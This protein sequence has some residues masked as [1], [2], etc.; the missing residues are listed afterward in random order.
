LYFIR[1]E[2]FVVYKII[3]SAVDE[4]NTNCRQVI[5]RIGGRDRDRT[6]DLMLAKQIPHLVE[7]YEILLSTTD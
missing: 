5:E 6:C 3:Y 2:D 1:D 4:K 7:I